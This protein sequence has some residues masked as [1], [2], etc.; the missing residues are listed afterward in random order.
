MWIILYDEEAKST[1]PNKGK[2]TSVSGRDGAGTCVCVLMSHTGGGGG[3]GGGR[4]GRMFKG[5]KQ[6]E[7]FLEFLQLKTAF[8][9]LFDRCQLTTRDSGQTTQASRAIGVTEELYHAPLACD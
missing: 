9:G 2:T 8:F 7:I 6:K 5:L 4:G 1:T 3:G